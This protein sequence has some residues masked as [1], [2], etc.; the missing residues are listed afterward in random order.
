MHSCGHDGHTAMLLGA[1]HELAR[2]QNFDGTVYFIFQPSEEHGLGAKAM[3]ADGLFTCW[4]ID[5]IYAKYNLL[6]IL[7]GHF[8]AR[9]GLI[10]ASK[11]SFEI[12]LVATGG[13]AAMPQ[14]STDPLVVRAQ[15]VTAI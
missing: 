1:A 12:D 6:E 13:H 2:T 5:A 9:L 15:I 14:M 7:E 4:K 11:S 10:M 8:V 3:I